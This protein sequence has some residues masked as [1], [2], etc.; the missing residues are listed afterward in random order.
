VCGQRSG[1]SRSF[2]V[3]AIER[4][5]EVGEERPRVR[6]CDRHVAGHGEIVRAPRR[7][8]HAADGC[9]VFG[10]VGI[11]QVEALQLLNFSLH[12]FGLHSFV[13]GA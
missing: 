1:A 13:G 10:R 6:V 9:L 2:L 4:H 3:V 8:V 12:D 5:V 7:R 11:V